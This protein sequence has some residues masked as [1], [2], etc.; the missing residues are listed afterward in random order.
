MRGN[1]KIL[2]QL[3]ICIWDSI[4]ICMERKIDGM[5]VKREGVITNKKFL[6]L[7]EAPR[8]VAMQLKYKILLSVV[9]SIISS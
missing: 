3:L 9:L 4:C 5:I 8:A 7:K 2:F 6:Y 1:Q